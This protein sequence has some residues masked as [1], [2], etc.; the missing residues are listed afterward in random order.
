MRQAAPNA[1][2]ASS[3]LAS[4]AAGLLARLTAR[5]ETALPLPFWFGV[6]DPVAFGYCADADVAEIDMPAVGAPGFGGG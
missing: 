1:S 4:G 2:R 6:Q 5:I 3:K